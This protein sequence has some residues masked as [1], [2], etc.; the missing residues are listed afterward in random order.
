MGARLGSGPGQREWA[1]R[2]ALGLAVVVVGLGLG[3]VPA[4]AQAYAVPCTSGV[5]SVPALIA[6][7]NSANG[8][9]VADVITLQPGCTYQ[10]ASVH[11]SAMGPNGLPVITSDI[12]IMGEGAMSTLTRSTS[13]P[14]LRF[15]NVA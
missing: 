6:A 9:G 10:V 8:N 1:S 5:G 7:I 2:A 11:N 13:G 14:A 15:F 4:G 3:V 12:T